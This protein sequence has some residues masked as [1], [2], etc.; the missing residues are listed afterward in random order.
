MFDDPRNTAR[1]KVTQCLA[2]AVIADKTSKSDDVFSR[3]VDLKIEIGLDLEC[4][5]EIGIQRGQRSIEARITDHNDLGIGR[6]RFGSKALRRDPA[7]KC[8]RFFDSQLVVLD[9]PL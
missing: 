2:V 8:T 5:A 1:I 6:D 3:A 9:H 4:L 7:K